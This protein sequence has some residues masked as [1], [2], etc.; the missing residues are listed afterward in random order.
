M[1]FCT[2]GLYMSSCGLREGSP[3][4]S[5][6]ADSTVPAQTSADVSTSVPVLDLNSAEP[7]SRD[8]LLVGQR[9]TAQ[10]MSGATSEATSLILFK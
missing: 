4:S 8:W 10:L 7:L 3:S 6:W 2:A 5:L 9:R 1:L